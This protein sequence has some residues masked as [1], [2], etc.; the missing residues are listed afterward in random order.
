MASFATHVVRES[1]L[2]PI[3]WRLHKL[4]PGLSLDTANAQQ[5]SDSLQKPPRNPWAPWRTVWDDPW[6]VGVLHSIPM[7]KICNQNVT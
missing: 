3:P 4:S 7:A 6:C 5:T 2:I 1:W